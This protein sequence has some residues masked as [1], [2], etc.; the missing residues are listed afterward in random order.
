MAVVVRERALGC[1]A[2]VCEDQ[3]RA[4]FGRYAFE[5]LAVPG[6]EG[7][8]EDAG[9]WAEFGVC[10]EAYAEAIAVDWTAVVLRLL[11]I[12]SPDRVQ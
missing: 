4:G 12:P 8:G 9:F 10:V 1:G 2:D 11:S 7:R 5:V 3:A 6:G